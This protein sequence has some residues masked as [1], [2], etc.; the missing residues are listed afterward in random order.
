MSPQ[1]EASTLRDWLD[2]HEPVTV[3]DIRTDDDYAQ[4]AIPGSLHVNAYEALRNG[5]A[6]TPR[7]VVRA[8]RDGPGEWTAPNGAESVPYVRASS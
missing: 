1:I 4:W 7:G 6:G 8:C 5:E 3:V 2:A